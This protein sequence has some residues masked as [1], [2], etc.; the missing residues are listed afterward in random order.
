MLVT[1][2]RRC[3]KESYHMGKMKSTPVSPPLAR[4]MKSNAEIINE[5]I[6]TAVD[7]GLTEDEVIFLRTIADEDNDDGDRIYGIWGDREDNALRKLKIDMKANGT[8]PSIE[9]IKRYSAE[10]RQTEEPVKVAK[11]EKKTSKTRPRQVDKELRELGDIDDSKFR[12]QNVM[13]HLTYSTHLDFEKW[14]SFM[15][16]S[17]HEKGPGFPIGEYSFVHETG[18]SEY[19]HTH[20]LIRFTKAAQSTNPRIFDFDG[21]HPHIRRVSTRKHWDNIIKY[22]EKQ[23]T[24]IVELKRCSLTER[25]QSYETL[26]EAMMY[27]CT[28]PGDANGIDRI[29]NMR[30]PTRAGPPDDI[31]E[32]NPWQ[33]EII[34]LVKSKPDSRTIEWI[35][36]PHGGAGKTSLGQYIS[37]QKLGILT[38][39]GNIYHLGTQ[40]QTEIK[41]GECKDTVIFNFTRQMSDNKVYTALEQVKDGSVAVTKYKTEMIHWEEGKRPHVIVFANY[42]PHLEH[43]TVERWRIRPITKGKEFIHEA[44]GD[45]IVA[46]IE[47][48]YPGMS[49]EDG[50]DLYVESLNKLLEKPIQAKRPIRDLAIP[51]VERKSESPFDIIYRGKGKRY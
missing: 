46:W 48:N 6:K 50:T 44:W 1:M 18:D 39:I 15:K 36:D 35:Y 51:P 40:L 25:I 45:E 43:M 22:H 19:P 38:Y 23:G 42:F 32:W 16:S 21:I 24:P 13:L 30:N 5:T 11:E 17:K 10:Q 37:G 9:E 8:Y 31:E 7:N 41:K 4:R 33:K 14:M 2:K 20:I 28:R 3:F 12:I 47:K 29:F 27:E 26:D 34:E 49:V